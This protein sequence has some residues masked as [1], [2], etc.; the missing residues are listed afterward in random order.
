MFRL[1]A[2]WSP[3]LSLYFINYYLRLHSLL[4]SF[5]FFYFWC[6]LT[7][8]VCWKKIWAIILLF[9]LKTNVFYEKYMKCAKVVKYYHSTFIRISYRQMLFVVVK[10][11]WFEVYRYPLRT[12]YI[13]LNFWYSGEGI[14]ENYDYFRCCFK[15]HI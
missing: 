12:A 9:S 15:V 6:I 7:N 3:Q 10:F 14:I 8:Y 11:Y 2:S 1:V 4:T 5:F 13:V